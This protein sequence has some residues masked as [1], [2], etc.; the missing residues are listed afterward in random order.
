M[1]VTLE[2]VR[3][4]TNAGV[5]DRT[6]SASTTPA[7][8]WPPT[9]TWIFN[10]EARLEGP[11]GKPIAGGKYGG[12]ERLETRRG[13]NKVGGFAYIFKN[14]TSRWTSSRSST[15]RQARSSPAALRNYELKERHPVA[16]GKM[17]RDEVLNA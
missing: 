15:K 4:K 12:E 17:M 14:P 6:S 8:P 13:P 7:T 3:K 10:N 11:D 5:G 2:E 1:A 9:A 16:V